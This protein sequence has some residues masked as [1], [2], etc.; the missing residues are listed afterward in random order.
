[1]Q[2]IPAI[3]KTENPE[4]I[5]GDITL[6]SG[7]FWAEFVAHL[8]QFSET[9]IEE[10]RLQLDQLL[11]NQA[12]PSTNAVLRAGIGRCL[13]H[14]GKFIEG[15]KE[16][17]RAFSMLDASAQDAQA[18]VM[19]EMSSFM[20]ITA[21]Y[22]LALM[23]LDKIPTLTKNA[24]LLKLANYYWCVVK[25][26]MGDYN[27]V[28][29]LLVSLEYFTG[30]N[31]NAT[32]AYHYKNIANVYRKTKSFGKSREYYQKGLALARQ[33]KFQHIEAAILHDMGMLHYY[34]GNP[35]KAVNSLKQAY[36]LAE[37]FYTRSFTLGNIGFIQKSQDN[38]NSARKYLE[39][40]LN[41]AMTHGVYA[42]I[43][44]IAH[45]L[46]TSI[47]DPEERKLAFAYHKQAYDVSLELLSNHFPFT[48]DRKRAVISYTEFVAA[49]SSFKN[50]ESTDVRLSFA[51]SKSLLE[52]RGIFQSSV[53][54]ILHNQFGTVKD[55]VR[56]LKI[57]VRT[58]HAVR[59]RSSTYKPDEPPAYVVEFL[60]K[61]DR[62]NWK[63]LNQKFE[64]EILSYLY[65][66]SNQNKRLLSE[67]LDISYQHAVKLTG[68]LE[69]HLLKHDDMYAKH[70]VTDKL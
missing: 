20:A 28:D 42:I 26:R 70:Q 37:N 67:K 31:E 48:G 18:F 27:L 19:L 12:L 38:I 29:E 11:L 45:H 24:Y 2:E 36:E 63:D 58:Y 60:S 5:S 69:T 25:T 55:L 57:P 7:S 14:E 51:L 10:T 49:H 35:G 50:V 56:D 40:S 21:Q 32:V 65:D 17:G 59:D 52:I 34:Q 9:S 16:L 61:N 68:N 62:L 13:V 46:A 53:L 4:P 54:E 47:T 1:M 64:S 23:L 33:N 22:E 15:A 3:F 8:S 43:P 6:P 30:I 44:T 66:Q 39:R 41:L